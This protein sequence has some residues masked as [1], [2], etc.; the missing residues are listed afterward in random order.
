MDCRT[1]PVAGSTTQGPKP[2]IQIIISY[3]YNSMVGL[4]ILV[5]SSFTI[6]SNLLLANRFLNDS[7]ELVES[8][9]CF[10]ICIVGVGVSDSGA[11]AGLT[12]LGSLSICSRLARNCCS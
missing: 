6:S 8:S 7:S 11:V 10:L 3:Y 4:L 1:M 12:G 2:I 9:D 5:V